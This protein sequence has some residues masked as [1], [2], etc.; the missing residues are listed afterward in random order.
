ML[1]GVS[2][3]ISGLNQRVCARSAR[4]PCRGDGTSL[5]HS[6]WAREPPKQGFQMFNEVGTVRYVSHDVR[7]CVW[8]TSVEVVLVK[9]K[10]TK[11]AP[12]FERAVGR[13]AL[14][15]R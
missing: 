6:L 9:E 15:V 8:F 13:V 1:I 10:D 3:P 14:T 11:D 2:A 12:C 5:H 7:A 4:K